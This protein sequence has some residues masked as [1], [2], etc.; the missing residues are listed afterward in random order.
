MV[1]FLNNNVFGSCWHFLLP[2]VGAQENTFRY[3]RGN[4][5]S[6][7]SIFFLPWKAVFRIR[8]ILVQIRIFGSLPRTN[9]YGSRSA[10]FVSDLQDA[11]KNLFFSLFFEGAALHHSSHINIINKSQNSRNQG[12]SFYFCLM[13]LCYYWS[14]FWFTCHI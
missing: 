10:S 4:F 8:D 14:S 6:L 5:F 13:A 1:C 3:S 7:V 12:V 9:G 2:T 11:N